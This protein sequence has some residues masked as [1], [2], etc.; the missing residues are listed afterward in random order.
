MDLKATFPW[1]RFKP[2]FG[3]DFV[4]KVLHAYGE[5]SSQFQKIGALE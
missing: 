5:L 1:S 3:G 4:G 2:K